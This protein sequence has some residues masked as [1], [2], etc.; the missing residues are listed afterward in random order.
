MLDHGQSSTIDSFSTPSFRRVF[1]EIVVDMGVSRHVRADYLIRD[2]TLRNKSCSLVAL[3]SSP[4]SEF[5]F[6]CAVIRQ[7]YS[8]CDSYHLRQ[9]FDR[10]FTFTTKS[11]IKS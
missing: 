5:P 8:W 3:R 10:T 11:L 7:L 9:I 2:N 1:T 4:T 6:L